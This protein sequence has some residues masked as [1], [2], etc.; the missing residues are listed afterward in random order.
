VV[1]N[2]FVTSLGLNTIQLTGEI[3]KLATETILYGLGT[4]M[5]RMLNFF[6][7]PLQTSVF[8]QED[9]GNLSESYGYMAFANIVFLFGMETAFF[10]FNNRQEFSQPR[11]LNAA[12]TIV[13]F[14]SS[15]ITIT[16]LLFSNS[17][18]S[19]LSNGNSRVFIW[20]LLTIFIDAIVAIPFAQLR[21]KKEALKF[22]IFKLVNV[23]LLIGLNL[24]FLLY[25]ENPEIELVFLANFIANA[26]YLLFF[27]RVLIQWRPL[28]DKELTPKMLTYS[29]PIVFTG[30]AGMTNEMFSR[31][32]IDN[33]LP[34]NFYPGKSSD[35][36]QGVFAAC[37]RF[38]VFMSLTVQAFRFAAEPFFFS[39]AQDKNSP[40]VFAKVNSYFILI[41]CTIML[42]I[43]LNMDW[44]KYFIDE[45]YWEGL[46]IVPVLLLGYIFLGIYYNISI[47]F[48][49]TDK[50]YFGTFITLG[51]AFVTILLNYIMIPLYGIM[52]SSLVTLICY[53]AM[54]ISCYWL[55]QRYFPVPYY[56]FKDLSIIVITCLLIYLNTQLKIDNYMI[57]I[58]LRGLISLIILYV[59][60]RITFRK[61]VPS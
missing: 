10:R 22:T 6:L 57:S 3:R 50:T 54:T 23:G 49:V 37:Y 34:K 46:N 20:I 55:G 4:I 42:G 36:I 30:I 31:I 17:L 1:F 8:P 33:W 26:F 16:F 29:Y 9:Y 28:F 18:A 60:F 47:W 5:P 58:A 39:K 40:E 44:L 43:C 45:G 38:S 24:Y 14:I 41:A 61:S 13:V 19:V 52:G 51:G 25:T 7:V 32:A 15:S 27:T 11:V 59:V 48:K 35:Y 12:Q 21:L 53:F 56:L 2:L